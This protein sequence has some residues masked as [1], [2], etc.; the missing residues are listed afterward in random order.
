MDADGA[1]E[2]AGLVVRAG[3]QGRAN[4]RIHAQKAVGRDC[5]GIQK[6]VPAPS[7][8]GPM[9]RERPPGNWDSGYRDRPYRRRPATPSRI[10]DT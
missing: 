7:A 5:A 2:V 8:A 3:G 4:R 10:P 6:W 1:G 9:A